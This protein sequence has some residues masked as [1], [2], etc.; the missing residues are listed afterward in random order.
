[1]KN[2]DYIGNS[3]NK[4]GFLVT[5]EGVDGVGKSTQAKILKDTILAKASEG[6][7]VILTKEPYND[8]IRN[9]VTNNKFS[10]QSQL[11]LFLADRYEHFQKIIKP[12]L[13]MGN[14]IICDRFIDSTNIY[15]TYEL[16]ECKYTQAYS[17]TDKEQIEVENCEYQISKE[18][19]YEMNESVI[20]EYYPDVTFYLKSDYETVINNLKNRD[21][22]DMFESSRDILIR[23]KRFDSYFKNYKEDN[24]Y[25]RSKDRNIKTINCKNRTIENIATEIF[26]EYYDSYCATQ[27]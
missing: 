26:D 12:N 17:K 7:K 24:K 13:L 25:N 20:E 3:K 15:Q 5:F 2:Q 18:F 8:D 21:K 6:K 10:P 16:P 22:L 11:L 4:K 23:Q 1:M 14:I 9:L 19:A 27:L